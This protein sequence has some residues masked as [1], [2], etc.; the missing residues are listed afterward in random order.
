MTSRTKE[1]ILKEKGETMNVYQIKQKFQEFMDHNQDDAIEESWVY[2]K[3][4]LEHI[5]IVDKDYAE[6]L[7]HLHTAVK[8]DPQFSK[9]FSKNVDEHAVEYIKRLELQ[10]KLLKEG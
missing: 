7:D 10:N 1:T 3:Q 2:V 9:Y 5:E 8:N 4:L 6:V